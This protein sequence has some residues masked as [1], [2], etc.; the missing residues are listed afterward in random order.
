MGN[1]RYGYGVG[2]CN[3]GTPLLDYTS[4]QCGVFLSVF[5]W[6]EFL[7]VIDQDPMGKGIT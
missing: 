3:L 2:D 1:L 5:L 6:A 4:E 7:R